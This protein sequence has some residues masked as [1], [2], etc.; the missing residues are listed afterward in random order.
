MRILD[1]S[2]LKTLIRGASFFTTGGGVPVADQIQTINR[3]GSKGV[4]LVN[5]EDLPDYSYAITAAEIGPANAPQIEKKKVIK[6]MVSVLEKF[7]GKK[8]S[9]IY[10]PEIGQESVVIESASILNLPIVDFDPTGFRAVPFMDI[11]IFNLKK[12]SYSFVPIVVTNDKGD[13][14]FIEGEFNYQKVEDTLRNMTSLSTYNIL[15]MLGGLLSV[16]TLKKAG[17]NRKSY[18]RAIEFGLSKNLDEFLQK[19]NPSILIQGKV[20]KIKE[21]KRKGFL[22][23][24]VEILSDTKKYQLFIL[25]EAIFLKDGIGNLLASVPDRI[26]LINP[27]KFTGLPSGDIKIG[28]NLVIAVIN[29]EKEWENNDGLFDKARLKELL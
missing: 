17:I 9:G 11:N 14:F 16:K 8:I 24:I 5:V 25:N 1:H 20:I 7:T 3:L 4:T 6:R 23:E 13:I 19:I 29:G 10:P 18:S 2:L 12:I 26:L 15:F 21:E 28:T 22:F 27:D